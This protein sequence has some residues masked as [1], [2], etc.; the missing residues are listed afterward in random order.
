M[1]YSELIELYKNGK[2]PEDTR[3]QVEQDIEK[4]QAISEYLFD[5]E[6]ISD[7]DDL[8]S[9]TISDGSD[10]AGSEEV[11]FVKIVRKSIHRAFIKMGVIVGA[12]LLAVVLFVIFALPRIM[13]LFYYDP[14]ELVK[15]EDMESIK[16]ELDMSV[17]TE[18]NLPGKYRDYVIAENEGYGEYTFNIIN[19]APYIDDSKN[20]TGKIERNKLIMYDPNFF[21]Y[22]PLNVFA[23]EIAGVIG[24]I[25]TNFESDGAAGSAENA[26]AE[27]ANLKEDETYLA[28]ITLN[29]VVSYAEFVELS[30]QMPEGLY[31]IW[32]AICMEN[33]K[34]YYTD[35]GNV[36]F[37]FD[38]TCKQLGFNKEKYP[39]LTSFELSTTVPID[40]IPSENDT[41]THVVSM[42]RYMAEQKDFLSL[43]GESTGKYSEIADNVEQHGLNIY[44]FAAITDK[45]AIMEWSKSDSVAYIYTCTQY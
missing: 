34:G 8:T 6:E 2:L 39:N 28:F 36:G 24:G 40:E 13:N 14:T 42:L 44:G 29:E 3:Q 7:L 32:C 41:T 30:E 11:K 5:T 31:P 4:H 27:L 15:N 23:H 38:V 19:Y 1:K 25:Q 17:Y 37:N 43:M 18:L 16:F 45:S 10:D 35:I 20:V 22:P 33:E 26:F 9:G 21:R 12:V